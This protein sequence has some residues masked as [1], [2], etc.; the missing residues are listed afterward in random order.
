MRR[1]VRAV[2]IFIAMIL[3][4]AGCRPASYTS[5]DRKALTEAHAK[6]AEE[7]FAQNLPEAKVKSTEIYADGMEILCIIEGTY[8]DGGKTYHYAYD[9]RSGE[10]YFDRY[11][12]ETM[13]ALLALTAEAL[14]VDPAQIEYNPLYL[15]VET[16]VEKTSEESPDTRI[17]TLDGYVPAREDYEEY[18][19]EILLTGKNEQVSLICSVYTD[20]IPDYD[21]AVFEELSGLHNLIYMTPLKTETEDTVYRAEYKADRALLC[22][23]VMA[24]AGEDIFAGYC[25]DVEDTFAVDGSLLAHNDEIKGKVPSLILS[26]H[27]DGKLIIRIPDGLARPLVLAKKAKEY[28]GQTESTGD[29]HFVWKEVG[30]LGDEGHF[31]GTY[32]YYFDGFIF[33][34]N[35]LTLYTYSSFREESG[36]YSFYR[37]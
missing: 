15:C 12:E 37:E 16:A 24:K 20:S 3:L 27:S 25:Y 18:A 35:G 2:F 10:M 36:N 22:H 17:A 21:P 8:A 14:K 19:R 9:Y 1:Q 33:E 5:E 23:A 6:E 7:W 11:Y 34:K 4:L 26:V 13:E 30:S 31:A 28:R 32:E 29:R